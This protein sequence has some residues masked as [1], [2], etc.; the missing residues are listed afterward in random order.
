ML[1][2]ITLNTR[3]FANRRKIRMKEVKLKSVSGA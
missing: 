2:E 3:K 1:H